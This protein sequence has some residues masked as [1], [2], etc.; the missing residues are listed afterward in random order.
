MNDEILKN[1]FSSAIATSIAELITLPICTIKTNYQN[2]H[3]QSVITITTKLYKE[4]GVR[5]FYN[6]SIV[7]I[8]SQVFSTTSKYVF[9][10][11]LEDKNLPH[12]NKFLNGTIAGVISSLFTHPLDFVK[13]HWQMKTPIVPIIKNNVGIVYRGYNKTFIK[14]TIGSSLFFPLYDNINQQVNNPFYASLGSAIISTLI[15]HPIDYF[16]T[17][18]VYGLPFFTKNGNSSTILLNIKQCYKGLSLNLGRIVPNFIIIMTSIDYI[19]R[20]I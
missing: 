3:H 10:R 8:S 17:R 9:Y 4:N 5:I 2:S 6:S 1:V 11:Y 18:Q 16:K 12:T 15:I 14:A 20:L 7:A 13:I 19:K